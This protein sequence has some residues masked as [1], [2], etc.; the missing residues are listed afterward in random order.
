VA[1]KEK[2]LRSAFKRRLRTRIYSRLKNLPLLDEWR[3]PELIELSETL[4]KDYDKEIDAY[5]DEKQVTLAD[6]ESAMDYILE[7]LIIP[8]VKKTRI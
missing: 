3:S 2:T 7:K 5:L 1:K 6:A 8:E 4:L